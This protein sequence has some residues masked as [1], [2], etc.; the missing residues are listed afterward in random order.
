MSI[1]DLARYALLHLRGAR[2]EP[3]EILTPESFAELH[4]PQLEGYALG[5]NV[6]P[7]GTS[8]L[9]GVRQLQHLGSGGTFT[10]VIAIF[11]DLGLAAVAIHNGGSN[12]AAVADAMYSLVESLRAR[13]EACRWPERSLKRPPSTSSP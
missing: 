10:S 2:G 4:S 13:P 1:G 9:P 11:P 8:R 5:W 12:T 3:T 7:D 6:V